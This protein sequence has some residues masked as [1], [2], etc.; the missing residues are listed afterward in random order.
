VGVEMSKDLQ[1]RWHKQDAG[2]VRQLQ[3]RLKVNGSWVRS[4][5]IDYSSQPDE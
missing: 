4:V 5:V 1:S 3:Q 2:R